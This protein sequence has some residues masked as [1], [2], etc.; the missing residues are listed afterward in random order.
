MRAIPPI[1]FQHFRN[2]QNRGKPENTN[3]TGVVDG[4][5]PDSKLLI[6]LAVEDGVVKASGFETEGDRSADAPLS[7][8]TV[9]VVDRSI[10]ELENLKIE[11]LA[12]EYGM[13]PEHVPMFTPALE[14]V[15]AAV[16]NF[17]GLPNPFRFEGG[18]VCTCLSVREGRIRRAI[19][20]HDCKTVDEVSHWTRA[21]GGCRSCRPDII[22][23]IKSE[24]S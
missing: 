4:R 24:R 16:A 5:M 3:G 18:V 14:A 22:K 1:V 8:T 20:E 12:A 23:I 7:L 11:E 21:C 9:F 10:G 13:G 6:H 19:R 2:P 15:H 17:K